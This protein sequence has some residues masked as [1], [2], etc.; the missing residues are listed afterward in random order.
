MIEQ[1]GFLDR[2]RVL[3]SVHRALLMEVPPET[4]VIDVC[5]N[6]EQIQLRFVL[7]GQ[8]R[9]NMDEVTNEIEAEVEGD[10][11]P[12]A[13]VESECLATITF[14]SRRQLEFPFRASLT[15]NRNPCFPRRLR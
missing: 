13:S 2:V 10:F 12:D 8:S 7:G 3:L 9:Y 6:H 1:Q 5:W 15:H 14:P 11:L 4:R